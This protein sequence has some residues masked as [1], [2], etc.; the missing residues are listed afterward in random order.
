M[1]FLILLSELV[2]NIRT[3]AMTTS[4]TRQGSCEIRGWLALCTGVAAA[5]WYK[6]HSVLV[7]KR[8]SSREK[9]EGWWVISPY[10]AREN[11][12]EKCHQLLGLFIYHVCDEEKKIRQG[13]KNNTPY[14]HT[15][16][17]KTVSI[18]QGQQYYRVFHFYI[19]S[20]CK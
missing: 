7:K 10:F 15:K 5:G 1:A 11:K 20:D 12:S 4:R 8:C 14:L 17:W 16:G 3:T 19:H 6:P 13:R 2:S 18:K 9:M